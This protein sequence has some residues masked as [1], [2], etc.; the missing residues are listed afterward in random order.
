MACSWRVH[1]FERCVSRHSNFHSRTSIVLVILLLNLSLRSLESWIHHGQS[2]LF[3]NGTIVG[4]IGRVFERLIHQTNWQTWKTVVLTVV[5]FTS[6][7]LLFLATHFLT[8]WILWVK[9]R[10]HIMMRLISIK[11]DSLGVNII[12]LSN[13]HDKFLLFD[14]LM[15]MSW[16]GRRPLLRWFR[17]LNNYLFDNALCVCC[18]LAW[19]CIGPLS[20]LNLPSILLL[21]QLLYIIHRY[22]LFVRFCCQILPIS[23]YFCL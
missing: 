23:Q 2:F 9:N 15:V 17:L 5:V 3:W 1:R 21:H 10:A 19:R 22:G 6:K 14:Q 20:L 12:T 13:F 7:L 18:V 16:K 8:I 4:L 11:A